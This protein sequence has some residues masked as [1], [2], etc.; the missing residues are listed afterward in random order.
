MGTAEV[1]RYR[2]ARERGVS[3]SVAL[4]EPRRRGMHAGY[5]KQL[6]RRLGVI[7]SR[8]KSLWPQAADRQLG[9]L[10]WI[11][12]VCTPRPTATPLLSLNHFSLEV[13]LLGRR[14]YSVG[15]IHKWLALYR[16]HGRAGLAPRA[17]RDAGRS[18]SLSDTEAAVLLNYLDNHPELTASAARHR[19]R[20]PPATSQKGVAD[21]EDS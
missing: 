20:R 6:E 10:A 21:A 8:G 13:P 11:R 7:V 9:G 18:R 15:S 2:M 19:H 5:G 12:A 17:R 4:E 3:R 14:R 1:E 16:K